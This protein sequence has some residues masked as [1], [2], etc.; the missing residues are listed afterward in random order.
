MSGTTVAEGRLKR[1]V[2][3]H[4]PAYAAA[5]TGCREPIEKI[6]TKVLEL[7]ENTI[8]NGRGQLLSGTIKERWVLTL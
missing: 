2:F 4:L 5:T 1:D 7:A 6:E 8:V 3:R